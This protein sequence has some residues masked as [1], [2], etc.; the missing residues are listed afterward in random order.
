MLH[1]N[2]RGAVFAGTEEDIEALRRQ[3]DQEHCLHLRG[4]LEPELRLLVQPQL[5]RAEFKAEHYDKIGSELHMARNPVWSLLH[6]LTNDLQFFQQVRQIT[7]CGRIGCFGGR[8]YRLLPDLTHSFAWHDDLDEAG[9]MLG[10]SV[11]LS[12]EAYRGGLLEIRDSASQQILYRADP[13]EWGD[14][15]LFRIAP[16]LKHRVTCVEG[17]RSKTAFAG[18]FQSRPDFYAIL[19]EMR[20]ELVDNGCPDRPRATE[21]AVARR[22]CP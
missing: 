19:Q 12:T 8:V 9:R 14:A 3:F 4:L 21:T 7:G 13:L 1:L 6:F 10:M 18:W 2:R 5:D 17:P 22:E 20:A 11:N 16:H 15:L